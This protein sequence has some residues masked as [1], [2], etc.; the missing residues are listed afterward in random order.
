MAQTVLQL[1]TMQP[2]IDHTVCKTAGILDCNA[3]CCL[4]E[5]VGLYRM[6]YRENAI[7]NSASSS[8]TYLI[9]ARMSNLILAMNHVEVNQMMTNEMEIF[10]SDFKS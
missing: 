10:L 6:R 7:M 3:T 2:G 1:S 8:L 9:L 5:H 4:H